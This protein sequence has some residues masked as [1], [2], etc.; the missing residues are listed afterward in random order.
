MYQ[1]IDETTAEKITENRERIKI[2]DL[3]A[4]LKMA[5]EKVFKDQ[6]EV[7]AIQREIDELK[8]IGVKEIIKNV[9]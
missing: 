5:K 3:V 8:K 9:L 4:M 6:E 7:D 1:K 2:S